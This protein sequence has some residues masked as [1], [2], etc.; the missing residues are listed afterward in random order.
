[1]GKKSHSH[2]RQR[3]RERGDWVREE[4]KEEEGPLC[5]SS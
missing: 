2:A 1:M 4:G 3:E 5:P